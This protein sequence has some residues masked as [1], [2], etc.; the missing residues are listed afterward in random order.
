MIGYEDFDERKLDLE[1]EIEKKRENLPIEEN[2]GHLWS[3]YEARP[4]MEAMALY[5]RHLIKMGQ[6]RLA[7]K[8]GEELL[9]LSKKDEQGIRYSLLSLYAFLEEGEMARRVYESF[10]EESILFYL[11]I[12]VLYY[13]LGDYERA[14]VYLKKIDRLADDLFDFFYSFDNIEVSVLEETGSLACFRPGSNAELM[15]AIFSEKYL[16]D[17]TRG[18]ASWIVNSLL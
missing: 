11:P 13:K 7:T 3:I 18:F 16:Y 9:Y 6:Y 17:S 8:V 4:Y 5:M 10:K 15:K 14:K 12:L 1:R 2:I